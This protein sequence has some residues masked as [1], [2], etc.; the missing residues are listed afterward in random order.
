MR[1]QGAIYAVYA[2]AGLA[3]VAY[4]LPTCIVAWERVGL[5]TIAVLFSLAVVVLGALSVLYAGL[6]FVFR[7][8]AVAALDVSAGEV[9][10]LPEEGSFS[11]PV[12]TAGVQPVRAIGRQFSRNE[13]APAFTLFRA[14]G[15]LWVTSVEV[16]P[17][18]L[19]GGVRVEA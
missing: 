15:K 7:E 18:S 19:P 12:H 17:P 9:V 4:L 2:L 6:A 3:L 16:L 11:L 8:R 14:A 10:L 13:A 5:S 1:R